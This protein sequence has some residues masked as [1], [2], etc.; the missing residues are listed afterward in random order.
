MIAAFP[1]R[2]QG[3]GEVVG[4]ILS[5]RAGGATGEVVGHTLSTRA[6]GATQWGGAP[7]VT[8][9]SAHRSRESCEHETTE[10]LC[11]VCTSAALDSVGGGDTT[12]Y[13][14]VCR[15]CVLVWGHRDLAPVRININGDLKVRSRPGVEK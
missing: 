14:C 11:A 6:G 10:I 13:A 1:R 4:H 7:R 8:Y 12:L 15:V 2:E 9:G 3:G 5:T